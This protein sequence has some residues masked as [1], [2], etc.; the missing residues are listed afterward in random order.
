[1]NTNSTTESFLSISLEE[2]T[3]EEKIPIIKLAKGKRATL[4][5]VVRTVVHKTAFSPIK[6][7]FASCVQRFMPSKA[8][9][10]PSY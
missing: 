8:P 4:E 5:E 9:I 3:F 7:Q 6:T 1:M 10:C 2:T